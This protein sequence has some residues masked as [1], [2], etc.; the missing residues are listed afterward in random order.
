MRLRAP[1]GLVFGFWWGTSYN[2]GMELPI[3]EIR[4]A[5]KS[6]DCNLV[7][8]QMILEY[9]GIHKS[10]AEI[11]KKIKLVK[12]G[13][14]M[15]QNGMLFQNLGFKTKIITQS[16][17]IFT[18]RDRNLTKEQ[19]YDRIVARKDFYAKTK[20]Y[21]AMRHFKDYLDDGGEIQVKIPNLADI[22][23]SIKKGNPLICVYTSNF[24]KGK[25]PK[26]NYHTAVVNG[27]DDKYVYVTDPMWDYR[28]GHQKYLKEDFLY[29]F[30]GSLSPDPD[31]ASLLVIEQV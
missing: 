8:D 15:P 11:R 22:E 26:F 3:K 19:I 24:L 1:F 4:Q 14:Y 28:G 5:E 10:L 27:M 2:Y 16:P 13:S 23:A 31:N 12:I 18:N 7:C 29:A 6:V 21:N 9:Y 20:K 17:Y 25:T 30:W